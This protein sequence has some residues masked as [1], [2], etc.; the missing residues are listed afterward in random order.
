MKN[1]SASNRVSESLE[2]WYKFWGARPLV[3]TIDKPHLLRMQWKT[4]P[5]CKEAY[6]VR[7]D[8]FYKSLRAAQDHLIEMTETAS[9]SI[10]WLADNYLV[11]S[12][13]YPDT[14]RLPFLSFLIHFSILISETPIISFTYISYHYVR[15]SQSF[16]RTQLRVSTFIPI[17]F[18]L[19]IYLVIVILTYL[20]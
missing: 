3:L 8:P 12:P 7:V 6:Q 5:C 15:H 16:L 19:L 14:R 13:L 10:C 4:Y 20:Q 11:C 18:L 1:S 17:L 9:Y 2:G